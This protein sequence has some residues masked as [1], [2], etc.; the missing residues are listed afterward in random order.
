MIPVQLVYPQAAMAL[1]AG[2][3]TLAFVDEFLITLRTG[4]PSFRAA[5]DAVALGQEG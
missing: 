2:L 1:G 4:R 3:L 5:E